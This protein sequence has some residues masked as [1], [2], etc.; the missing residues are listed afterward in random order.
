MANIF[1]TIGNSI[2]RK[3]K[4]K[5]LFEKKYWKLSSSERM[6]YDLKKQ[7]IKDFYLRGLVTIDIFK[8]IIATAIFALSFGLAK[9]EL[10]LLISP[11]KTIFLFYFKFI[12]LF[13]LLDTVLIVMHSYGNKME[14]KELKKRFKLC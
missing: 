4:R 14:V 10:F 1:Q 8:I 5:E 12:Y 2:E 13:I 9:G 7:E 6:E 3:K 11:I